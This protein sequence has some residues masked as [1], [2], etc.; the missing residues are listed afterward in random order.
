MICN[1]ASITFDWENI[2]ISKK[3]NVVKININDFIL[4]ICIGHTD[5]YVSV[6]IFNNTGKDLYKL[7]IF[8]LNNN[9]LC[10][11]KVLY[12]SKFINV[13]YKKANK[14]N[15]LI[16]YIEKNNNEYNIVYISK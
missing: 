6:Y 16:C 10:E 9:F 8:D 12:K 7:K 13:K 5:T 4:S 3:S 11:T 15:L 2:S 1:V 14:P